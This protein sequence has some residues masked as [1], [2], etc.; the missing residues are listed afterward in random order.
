MKPS[1][2]ST[3]HFALIILVVL[4]A[5][6]P[7]FDS[8]PLDGHD[9]GFNMIRLKEVHT[10]ISH[11]TIIPRWAP[12]LVHGYGYPLFIFYPPLSYICAVPFYSMGLSLDASLKCVYIIGFLFAV[13]C[14]FRIGVR[15]GSPNAG[16]IGGALYVLAPYM[17]ADVYVRVSYSEFIAMSWFPFIFLMLL[18]FAQTDKR[19]F[20][21]AAI[22]GLAAVNLTHSISAL[23]IYPVSFLWALT[24]GIALRK[25][26]K[27]HL[28]ATLGVYIFAIG[29][30][31]FFWIPALMERSYVRI[32]KMIS[33]AFS[34]ENHFVT[35]AKLFS[36][37]WGY[38]VS[39]TG[40]P[41]EMSFQIGWPHITAISI[42]LIC[43]FY[44]SRQL[45]SMMAFALA[46]IIATVFCMLS[47]S[48]FVWKAIPLLAYLQFPW[49]LLMITALLSSLAG[50]LAVIHIE[51]KYS[52]RILWFACLAGICLY[53]IP[54][55]KASYIDDPIFAHS[56]E[57]N[58]RI[59]PLPY[60]SSTLLMEYLPKWVDTIPKYP[61]DT[62]FTA[63][64]AIRIYEQTE[65]PTEYRCT[66]RV[67]ASGILQINKFYYPGWQCHI[68]EVRTKI[69][70]TAET[71]IM[72][73]YLDTPGTHKVRLTFENT[74]LRRRANMFSLLFLIA[75]LPAGW[76]SKLHLSCSSHDNM[77]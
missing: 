47:A 62:L 57:H 77:K 1:F 70:T 65:L 51:K 53:A 2:Q 14:M 36:I 72:E 9:P 17:L 34:F 10:L 54:Y 41:Q 18:R 4:I 49:R 59:L 44:A 31:A 73:V 48:L 74:L 37:K 38:A 28:C 71:G 35:L 16:L 8:R 76:L 55:C 42:C 52:S 11:G 50:M 26:L 23:L 19:R 64:D 27:R 22:A 33:G 15:L 29:I 43:L 20:A 61:A 32:D 39:R 46:G 30:T 69:K 40:A 7:L 75:T 25:P 45:R 66:A 6:H 68:N 63:D 24:T 21:L 5:V 12:D 60:G 56:I 58:T 13:F 3:A 67:A